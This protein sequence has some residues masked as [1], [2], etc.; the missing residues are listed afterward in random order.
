MN[1]SDADALAAQLL[2]ARAVGARLPLPSAAGLD[3]AGAYRV[4]DRIRTRRTARGERPLGYKIGF[5]NRSIWPTYGVYAPIWAPV[6]DSSLTLLEGTEAVVSVAGFV[7]PRIEPEIVFGFSQTP[8][9]G[10][11]DAS[12][13]GCLAWVAHGIEIVHTHFDDWRFTAPDAVA[14]FGLHG[15]LWVGPRVPVAAFNDLARDLPALT[16][17]LHGDDQH[18]AT[19]TGAAVLG[20]PLSALRHWL[21]AMA[22]QCPAWT[23]KPGDAVTTGTLTDALPVAAGQA[24]QTQLSSGPLQGLSIRFVA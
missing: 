13:I 11:D 8:D 20:S 16:L 7:Q 1:A 22:R 23:V 18:R 24:W 15:G 17:S 6:W 2:A 14:D 21:D 4:A 10:A 3:L 12:L 9:A 5:T 19:G